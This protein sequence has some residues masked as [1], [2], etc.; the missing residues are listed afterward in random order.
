MGK[1]HKVQELALSITGP[2]ATI[3]SYLSREGNG[4]IVAY[5]I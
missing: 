5:L 1:Y 2:M 4:T 3:W